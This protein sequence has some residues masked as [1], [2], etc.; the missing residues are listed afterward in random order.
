[1]MYVDRREIAYETNAAMMAAAAV[2]MA[3]KAGGDTH[4]LNLTDRLLAGCHVYK[5]CEVL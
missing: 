2:M 4:S 5:T 1:L 3:A